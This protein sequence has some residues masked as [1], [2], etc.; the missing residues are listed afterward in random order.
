MNDSLIE[1]Y[2]S[3]NLVYQIGAALQ[4]IPRLLFVASLPLTI[5][6]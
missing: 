2:V 1:K 4:K 6:D 5:N 3:L